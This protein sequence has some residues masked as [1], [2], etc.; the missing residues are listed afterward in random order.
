DS[1][2]VHAR[3]FSRHCLAICNL[4]PD[5]TSTAVKETRSAVIISFGTGLLSTA[6]FTRL[7]AG[8]FFYHRG[9][10]GLLRRQL[11]PVHTLLETGWM[12]DPPDANEK[13]IGLL[14]VKKTPEGMTS[15]K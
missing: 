4:T 9:G 15:M 11:L 3:W 5:A 10:T 8:S 12:A 2:R 13:V 6:T 1:A 7:S 14:S